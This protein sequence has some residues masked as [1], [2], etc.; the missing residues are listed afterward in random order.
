MINFRFREDKNK[1]SQYYDIVRWALISH[2]SYY[3][4][5]KYANFLIQINIKVRYN[6]NHFLL[7]SFRSNMTC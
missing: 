7:L 1:P 3:E 2:S 6:F 4:V 5:L